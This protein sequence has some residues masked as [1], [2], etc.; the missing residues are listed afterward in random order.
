MNERGNG[1]VRFACKHPYTYDAL[2]NAWRPLRRCFLRRLKQP[3]TSVRSARVDTD[4]CEAIFF[5]VHWM[6]PGGAEHYALECARIAAR[7]GYKVVWLVDRPAVNAAWDAQYREISETVFQMWEYDGPDDA[8]RAMIELAISYRP[9]AWHIHHSAIAY[10]AVSQAKAIMPSLK[11]IDS[12][13]IIE[14]KDGGFPA[15]SA[16]AG[17]SIDFRNVISKG[18]ARYFVSRGIPTD[19]IRRSVIVQR[20]EALNAPLPGLAAGKKIVVLILGRLEQQKRPYLYFPFARAL[21]RQ[22]SKARNA[23]EVSIEVRIVGA[24][25]Y[26]VELLNFDGSVGSN[27]TFKV[28]QQ[29]FDKESLYQGVHFVVQLS[30]N[31]GIS[32]VG[33]EAILRGCCFIAT[34]VGQQSEVM[35][36]CFLVGRTAKNAVESAASLIINI[37]NDPELYARALEDQQARLKALTHHYGYESSIGRLYEEIRDSL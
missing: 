19:G 3:V 22:L 31:E 10:R 11:I 35:N 12:T 8:A 21:Q 20:Q 24:G 16:A 18:L 15:L 27:V 2:L 29:H 32:L 7:L 36:D 5:C 13:H 26:A 34:D 25:A 33:F 1:R 6:S 4:R 37:L 17:Q 30:E 28:Q 9:A 23:R 14:L